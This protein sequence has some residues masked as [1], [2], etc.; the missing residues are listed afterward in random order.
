MRVKAIGFA[1]PADQADHFL[2]HGEDF[3]ATSE[4]AYEE[5]AIAFLNGRSDRDIVEGIRHSNGGT[6]RFD[7]ATQTFAVMRSDGI[8]KTF[9]QPNPKWHGFSSNLAYFQSECK[10]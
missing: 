2:H 9:Y 7:R 4:I 10:K 5:M 1:T 8:V 3:D 6:V